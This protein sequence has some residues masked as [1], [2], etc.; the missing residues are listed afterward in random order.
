M[1]VG[2]FFPFLLLHVRN[3]TQST[4]EQLPRFPLVNNPKGASFDRE[5]EIATDTRTMGTAL[6]VPVKCKQTILYGRERNLTHLSWMLWQI[7]LS[8]FPSL[9]LSIC[10]SVSRVSLTFRKV[11]T[12]SI[13]S[14][15]SNHVA[16]EIFDDDDDDADDDDT[17]DV[18]DGWLCRSGYTCAVVQ[19]SALGWMR[20]TECVFSVVSDAASCGSKFSP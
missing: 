20:H 2:L 16:I 18:G 19:R 10:T 1:L 7:C 15:V 3:K 6:I 11:N 9:S 8:F 5:G 14:R 12:E 17:H 13:I 4:R